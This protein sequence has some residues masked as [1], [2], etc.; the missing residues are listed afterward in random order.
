MVL[1]FAASSVS[2]PGALPADVSDKTV[3]LAVY[4]GLGALV[5]RALAGGGLRRPGYSPRG[6]AQAW[7]VA[8]AYG[9]S[10]EWHQAFVPGRTVSAADW[11]ADAAGA[12]AS[13]VLLV[14][15]ARVRARRERAV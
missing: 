2:D 13:V 10:D 9:A 4:A 7:V 14:I 6:A 12:A 3:H 8:A 11:V 15:V 5:F 1:I